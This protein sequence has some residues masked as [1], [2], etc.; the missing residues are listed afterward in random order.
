MQSSAQ[1]D[2]CALDSSQDMCKISVLSSG[3][4]ANKH[5]KTALLAAIKALHFLDFPSLHNPS[6]TQVPE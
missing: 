2:C 4:S 5:S 3:C 6:T 1:L